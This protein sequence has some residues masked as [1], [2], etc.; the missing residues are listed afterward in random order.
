MNHKIYY[1][2]LSIIN[3]LRKKNN[4][5][6]RF[7]KNFLSYGYAQI[8][9]I[10]VQFISVPF[11]LSYWDKQRYAEWLLLSGIPIMLGLMDF[12]VAH[13]TSSKAII[14]STRLEINALRRSLQTGLVF[15]L[16]VAIFIFFLVVVVGPLLDLKTIL[17]LTNL[18]QDQAYIVLILLSAHLGIQLLGGPLNAWFLSMDKAARGFFMLANRRLVD[19]FI[20]AI[21]L[22]LG[23]NAP[24][25]AASM[26]ISQIILLA[27]LTIYAQNISPWPML[28]FKNASKKEFQSII[29]PAMGHAGIT[30]GHVIT[31]QGGIQIL[32]QIAPASIVV[33]YSMA[34]TFMRLLLQIGVITNHALRPELSRLLGAGKHAY[35][36]KL[37]NQITIVS[38]LATLSLYAILVFIGPSFLNWWSNKQI[39]A[40]HN[41]FLLMGIHAV[42]YTCWFLPLSYKMATNEHTKTG[43][44]YLLGCIL[45]II[46]WFINLKSSDPLMTA[47]IALSIPEIFVLSVFIINKK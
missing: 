3:K 31:L 24:V 13:A 40:N 26:L 2:I 45:G 25:L 23:G 4:I 29:K 7:S 27:A 5:V 22:V 47:A 16:S 39:S 33:V 32:N 8:V 42:I 1:Y 12:G 35:A 19:V 44:I 36:Q 18:S 15:S 14:L 43:V 20:T 10:A 30:I 37:V 38:L 34:R 46:F 6:N 41:T 21:V 28:G 11:F 17:K 9:T